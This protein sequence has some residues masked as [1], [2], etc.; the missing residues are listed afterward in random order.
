MNTDP[1][2]L[3]KN[4]RE[5]IQRYDSQ[6]KKWRSVTK[7]KAGEGYYLF[8]NS[9]RI[10]YLDLKP[11]TELTLPVVK[12]LNLIGSINGLSKPFPT[13]GDDVTFGSK[14]QE[15]QG[16]WWRDVQV[17]K[18]GLGYIFNASAK[19][20]VRVAPAELLEIRV[21]LEETH[22][23]QGEV[24]FPAGVYQVIMSV[25]YADTAYPIG[26]KFYS[27]PG[28]VTNNPIVANGYYERT[29]Y[30]VALAIYMTDGYDGNYQVTVNGVPAVGHKTGPPGREI[31]FYKAL[32]ISPVEEG[33]VLGY[34]VRIDE[35]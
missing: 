22:D 28:N 23:S 20:F 29:S 11:V 34:T 32:D 17:M 13:I 33:N 9:S 2:S 27:W 1:K 14:L 3:L 35:L 10:M 5:Y 24:I 16:S 31:W 21:R 8:S 26:S 12:G 25:G 19:G 30:S 18:E 7:L 6:L 4:S 15:L